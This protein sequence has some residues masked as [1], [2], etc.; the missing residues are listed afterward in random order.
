M[1]IALEKLN[2]G[3]KLNIKDIENKYNLELEN[4]YINGFEIEKSCYY[5]VLETNI[6]AD[7]LKKFGYDL[8]GLSY[9]FENDVLILVVQE[10]I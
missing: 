2:S 1:N 9:N 6:I 5:E 3:K 10:V 4:K 7:E 8:I